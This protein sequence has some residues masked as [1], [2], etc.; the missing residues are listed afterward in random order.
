MQRRRIECV[1]TGERTGCR[2]MDLVLRRRIVGLVAAVRQ[3]LDAHTGTELGNQ[4]ILGD[5]CFFK[6]RKFRHTLDIT[7]VKYGDGRHGAVAYD[8]L[9]GESRYL[10]G[11]DHSTS[12]HGTGDIF[13]SV[14]CG[15]ITKGMN[16]FD[17]VNLAT[18]YIYCSI[19]NT[20][21]D[22]DY[23]PNGVNFQKHLE[24]LINAK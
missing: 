12:F 17:A 19:K 23:E 11:K 14:V 22:L 6:S 3:N 5:I 21:T 2:Q 8:A 24:M 16:V 9:S 20:P 10:Y 1:L 15:G 4:L 13:S 18:D 7:G